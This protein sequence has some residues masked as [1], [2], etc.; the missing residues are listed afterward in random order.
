MLWKVGYGAD[1]VGNF[2][3]AHERDRVDAD[4]LAA[5]VVAVRLADGAHRDLCDLR[6]AADDDHTLAEDLAKWL[7]R[8]DTYDAAHFPQQ[9]RSRVAIHIA[10]LD[11]EHAG[12][13]RLALRGHGTC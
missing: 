3:L 2:L 10:R 1:G 12:D 13:V 8:L 11:V 4:P 6:A 7:A 5:Q 9:V